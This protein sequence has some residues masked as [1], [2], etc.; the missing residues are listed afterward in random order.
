MK[1]SASDLTC[2]AVGSSQNLLP[3]GA[4]RRATNN[5]VTC[6]PQSESSERESKERHREREST[7]CEQYG[8]YSL[9][10]T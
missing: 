2:L 6:F 4:L 9:F 5:M 8:S 3:C 7:D 10:V 1:I